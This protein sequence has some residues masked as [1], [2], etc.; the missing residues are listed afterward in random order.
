MF[1]GI[2]PKKLYESLGFGIAGIRTIWKEEHA[3]KIMLL[4]AFL[5]ILAMFFLGLPFI[6]KLLLLSIII[7]VL[8]LELVNSIIEKLLDFL[9][10]AR[11]L[12][13]KV[14]KDVMAGIVLL[15]L[16]GAAIIGVLVFLPYLKF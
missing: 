12:R 10:P 7:M 11:D 1:L 4:I 9:H 14:I 3:F 2:K 8:V 15:A 13:V 16:A 5:V 6:Q